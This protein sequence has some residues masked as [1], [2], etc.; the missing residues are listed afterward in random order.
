LNG[1][2]IGKQKRTQSHAA[3]IH[4]AAIERIE[5]EAELSG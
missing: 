3:K 5:L 1:F 4:L 2:N